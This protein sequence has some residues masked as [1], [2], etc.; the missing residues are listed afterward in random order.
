MSFICICIDGTSSASGYNTKYNCTYRVEYKTSENYMWGAQG[1]YLGAGSYDVIETCK[2]ENKSFVKR[3]YEAVDPHGNLKYFSEGPNV[4]GTNVGRIIDEAWA[5]LTYFLTEKPE[6][7]VVL[8]GHSRGG[9]IVTALAHKL[10]KYHVGDFA[11]KEVL[12]SRSGYCKSGCHMPPP[13]LGNPVWGTITPGQPMGGGMGGAAWPGSS[14]LGTGG[15][16]MPGMNYSTP[17]NYETQFKS[18]VE[19]KKV[20]QPHPVHY[21]GLYDAVD[22]TAF[23]GGDTSQIPDNVSNS[24]HAIRDPKLGSREVFSNTAMVIPDGPNHQQKNFF[25]THGAIGGAVPHDCQEDHMKFLQNDPQY[26]L[27]SQLYGYAMERCNV[28]L[29]VQANTATGEEAHQYILQGARNIGVPV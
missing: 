23:S 8:I 27:E 15:W 29:T 17:N 19:E 28:P 11:R 25:A 9:H 5:K 3:F 20:L 10:G 24:R 7:R 22:R 12:D 2:N 21:L 16:F 26:F 6:A 18:V 14:P 13:N 1:G 4:P